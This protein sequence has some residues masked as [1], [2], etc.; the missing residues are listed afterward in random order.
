MHRRT[1]LILAGSAALLFRSRIA[2]EET[3]HWGYEGPTGPQSWSKEFPG[4][5]GRHQSPV[6]IRGAQKVSGHPIEFH[7]EDS[8]LRVVNNGHTIMVNYDPGSFITVDARQFQLTQ[9]HFHRPSE[10]R[11]KGHTFAFVCHLVHQG[12]DGAL[13]VVA[14]LF[15]Q[16]QAHPLIDRI[17]R[18]LP[19][20][21][22][23]EATAADT[24]INAGQ[25][26]PG[27]HA[28][29]RYS[30]SLTTPPCTEGVSWHILMTPATVSSQQLAAFPFKMN[31]R[32][33][34]PLN[35]RRIEED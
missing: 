16:G 18:H 7:Y 3:H 28:Y 1:A 10:E 17:W 24:T 2:A 19:G 14:V 15:E 31:A 21:V 33:V 30:G 22:G 26:L 25:F 27:S 5:A 11:I 6:D 29:Y 13:A 12:R 20:A 4:C 32:P 35:D 34:Q 8:R 23:E 9:F